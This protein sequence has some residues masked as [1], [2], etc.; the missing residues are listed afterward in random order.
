MASAEQ[1][2]DEY[3]K[4]LVI[5][6]SD[7]GKTSLVFRFVDGSFSSQFVSTVGIDFKNKTI[8]WNYKRIQ[9]Q[10]W[11]TAGQERYRSLTTA[12]YRGAAGFIIVYDI[13]NEISFK[14]VQ[15]WVSQIEGNSGPEAKK[16]LVGNMSDKEKERKVTRERGQ[17]LA[18]QL[19]AEFIE[20]SVKDNSNVEKVFQ[21]LVE[22]ILK[23]KADEVPAAEE[24]PPATTETDTIKLSDK[25]VT[26]AKDGCC[27]C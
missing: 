8:V 9:L 26:A 23:E 21:L 13:T 1:T 22:S 16:I 12:Y 19:G 2:F 3:F 10:I 20:I 15:E 4:I 14:D 11:D 18:D 6:D 7:V 27:N 24:K 17:Q 5:G 25:P